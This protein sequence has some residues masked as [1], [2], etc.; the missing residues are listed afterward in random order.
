MVKIEQWKQQNKTKNGL[1]SEIWR[2]RETN[3]KSWQ[4]SALTHDMTMITDNN[5]A[6]RAAVRDIGANKG[7]AFRRW[8]RVHSQNVSAHGGNTCAVSHIRTPTCISKQ[9]DNHDN[10]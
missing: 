10:C 1:C 4:G 7:Q 2:W 5:S 9:P 3:P 6:L 8:N